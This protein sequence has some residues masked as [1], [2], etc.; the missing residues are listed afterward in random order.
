MPFLQAFEDVAQHRGKGQGGQG[1]RYDC[2]QSPE[3]EGVPLPH[4]ELAGERDWVGAG[5]VKEGSWLHR[6]V[7][8]SEDTCAQVNER[9]DEGEL[10]REDSVDRELGGGHAEA[11][12]EC[13]GEAKDGGG[14]Q[15]GVNADEQTDGDA[16]GEPTRSCS[17]AQQGKNRQEG[18]PIEKAP[19]RYCR[20]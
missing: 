20:L 12:G 11:E 6:Q 9:D 10:Q 4:P 3:N 15:N 8:G 19:G 1:H 18:S 7:G 14:A 17:H 16:P 2:D 5:G 13:G